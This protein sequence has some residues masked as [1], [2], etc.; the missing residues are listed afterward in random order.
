MWLRFYL[1]CVVLL[2]LS[3]V[4]YGGIL[5]NMVSSKD[6]VMVVLGIA[7]ALVW[8]ALVV[9]FVYRQIKKKIKHA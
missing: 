5:P 4:L 8:P 3:G 9:T 7:G 2:I 1:Y 6:T